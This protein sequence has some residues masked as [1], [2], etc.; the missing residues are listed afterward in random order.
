[1]GGQVGGVS[2]PGID[3]TLAESLAKIE[4]PPR[5]AIVDQVMA[6][7]QADAPDYRRL[8]SLITSD[9]GLAA[10]LVKT[11][12]APIFGFRTRA[13]TVRDALTM[14]GLLM[15]LRTVAGYALRQV[16]PESPA[17]KGFWDTSARVAHV[18]GWLVRETGIADGVRPQDAYT[19][20]LFRD[21]GIPVLMRV[22]DGYDGVLANA[23]AEPL[24]SFTEV[25]SDRFAINHAMVGCV[26]AHSWY[27]PEV[28]CE[29]I[30]HHHDLA[31]LSGERGDLSPA[32]RRL[33]ALG[34]LAEWLQAEDSVGAAN[35]W[36][37][38]GDAVL[39]LLDLTP[40][41]VAS[42]RADVRAFLQD[43]G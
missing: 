33:V 25:E 16:L 7:M 36:K 12:N 18:S 27:L 8:A 32:A 23:T 39:A 38:L 42:M 6:E 22:S 19:Y 24:K 10:W 30:L 5:P 14:L 11:A 4:I 15:V 40:M 1:M 35:E 37:K 43:V 13:M 3:A 20:G 31:S 28:Q 29:A 34:Q 41:Q 9:V 2:I 17:L 26:M 21:C